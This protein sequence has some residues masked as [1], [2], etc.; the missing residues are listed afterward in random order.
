MSEENPMVA[1]TKKRL[2]H[3]R[4]MPET[5]Q[6]R[7]E[8]LSLVR[9]LE[10]IPLQAKAATETKTATRRKQTIAEYDDEP[11]VPEKKIIRKIKRADGSLEIIKSETSAASTDSSQD[12][13]TEERDRIRKMQ[14][15]RSM[16]GSN[17]RG[18]S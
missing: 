12:S 3:L 2:I 8:I 6:R 11:E 4:S 15:I 7:R 13:A 17:Y 18:M 10:T 9:V 5:P 16:V 14:E 1:V